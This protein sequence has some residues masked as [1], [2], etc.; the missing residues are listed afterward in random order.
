MSTPPGTLALA[1]AGLMLIALGAF[2]DATA[3]LHAWLAALI[4]WSAVPIGALALVAL[5]R[6]AGG[7]WGPALGPA[8]GAACRTLPLVGVL[9][10]P[11]LL[12]SGVIYPWAQDAAAAGAGQPAYFDGG[13]FAVRT[14]LYFTAWILLAALLL[15]SEAPLQA[16]ARPGLRGAAALT[17]YLLTASL[18]AVDW[19]MSLEPRFV[20]SVYPL[21]FVT[22]QL[23]AA[24]AFATLVSLRRGHAAPVAAVGALL[25]AGVLAWAFLSYIQYLVIWS[26][27]LPP[28]IAWYLRRFE[29][30]WDALLWTVALLH[31]AAGLA[32][33]HPAARGRLAVVTGIAGLLLTMR[34]LE[35]LWL[36]LPAFETVTLL[37]VLTALLGV[38]ALWGAGFVW[39][40]SAARP[41]RARP[42]REAR[43]G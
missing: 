25:L 21:L 10:V 35:A 3:F 19:A 29:A 42:L 23:I 34:L 38:G 37:P 30:P 15:R 41:G 22:H 8:L 33:L 4:A 43:H 39:A 32:L 18:A 16:R 28:K 24:L 36:V 14:L 20:S 17:V 9:F 6:L 26:G 5:N 12:G 13:F 31:G 2:L 11:V 7:A 27:D 40:W 1:V